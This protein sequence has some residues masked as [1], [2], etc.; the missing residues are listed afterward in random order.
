MKYFYFNYETCPR[1]GYNLCQMGVNHSG[2]GGQWECREC[3]Y[4]WTK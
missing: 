1:C 2:S 4:I 3:G